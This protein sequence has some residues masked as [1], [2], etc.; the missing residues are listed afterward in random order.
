[1]MERGGTTPPLGGVHLARSLYR[2]CYDP[3]DE[4]PCV[5]EGKTIE[6]SRTHAETLSQC[7]VL[8]YVTSAQRHRKYRFLLNNKVCERTKLCPV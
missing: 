4:H 7:S 6:G 2:V 8:R 5:R 1:M 3:P